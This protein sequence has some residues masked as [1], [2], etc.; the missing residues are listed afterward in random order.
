MAR[1]VYWGNSACGIVSLLTFQERGVCMTKRFMAVACWSLIFP[2]FLMLMGCSSD[3]GAEP[4][5]IFI[6]FFVAPQYMPDGTS[7]EEQIQALRLWLAREAGGYTEFK[8]APGG[9]IDGAGNLQTEEQVAFLVSAPANL[10]EAIRQY[11]SRNFG[12]SLPYVVVWES[13]P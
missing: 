7:S 6:H 10:K 2:A 1:G 12:Q 3:S 11:M 4:D 5:R 9:W 8:E 13:L